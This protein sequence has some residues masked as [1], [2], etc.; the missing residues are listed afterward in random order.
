MTKVVKAKNQATLS[1]RVLDWS[2]AFVAIGRVL[3]A[4]IEILHRI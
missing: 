2:K 4:L 1:S 3:K